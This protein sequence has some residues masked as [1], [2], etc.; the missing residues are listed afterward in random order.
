MGA[1]EFQRNSVFRENRAERL[2]IIGIEPFRRNERIV[3]CFGSARAQILK[4][5]REPMTTQLRELVLEA[6]QVQV[7]H[8]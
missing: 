1:F 3:K 8:Q 4:Q 7:A 6:F 2:Q 5:T